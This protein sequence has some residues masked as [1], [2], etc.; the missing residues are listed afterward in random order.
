M[1]ARFLQVRPFRFAAC[2]LCLVQFTI[3]PEGNKSC[4]QLIDVDPVWYMAFYG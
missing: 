1:L 2:S 3:F 4:S